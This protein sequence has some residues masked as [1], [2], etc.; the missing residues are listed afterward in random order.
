MA[1]SAVHYIFQNVVK[2]TN[3]YSSECMQPDLD[4]FVSKLPN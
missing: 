3:T 2:I 1:S 4:P